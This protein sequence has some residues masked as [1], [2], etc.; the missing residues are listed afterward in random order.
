MNIA[1]LALLIVVA[2][3]AMMLGPLTARA[4]VRR[5]PIPA[6]TGL[7]VLQLL[8]LA[9]ALGYLQYAE[10]HMRIPI[11]SYSRPSWGAVCGLLAL[12]QG[13]ASGIVFGSFALSRIRW[14]G[15]VAGSCLAAVGIAFVGSGVIAC[16]NGNCF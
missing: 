1:T 7:F 13:V 3:A 14:C 2:S 8:P 4:Q 11:F 10:T 6:L 9:L 16:M 12:A 15:Y 5:V